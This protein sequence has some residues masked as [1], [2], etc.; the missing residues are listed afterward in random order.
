MRP[1]RNIIRDRVEGGYGELI[2]RGEC[3]GEE[4]RCARKSFAHQIKMLDGKNNELFQGFY[5]ISDIDAFGKK[6]EKVSRI[7]ASSENVIS[8]LQLDINTEIYPLQVGD[9]FTLLLAN[10]L[11]GELVDTTAKQ[12]YKPAVSGLADDYD[13]VM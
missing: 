6:F 13:Y 7:V 1:D 5:E 4:L 12:S 8:D 11:D 9:K 2:C 3:N 10:S